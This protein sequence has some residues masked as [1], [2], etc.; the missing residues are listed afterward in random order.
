[1]SRTCRARRHHLIGAA[2]LLLVAGCTLPEDERRT[3]SS[4]RFG[5]TSQPTGVA[6]SNADL[7][8][9]FIDLT[10]GLE[11]GETLDGLLR[12]E[13][14]VQVMMRGRELAPYHRDLTAL[15]QR[16]R[17]E[18][19]IDITETGDP[20]KAEI[21]IEAVPAAQINRFFPDAACFIVPGVANWR[22]FLN[23]RNDE[24][25]RWSDQRTLTHSVIF[26]PPDSTPQDARDCLNEEITQALGPANDL[27]RLPDS[28]WND[29]NFQ[30][31]A[32]A[33]DM[34]MLRTLY[35]PEFASGMSRAQAE[36]RV[37]G[38]LDRVNPKGRGRPRQRRAPES[39]AWSGTI[40]RA[41]S[42]QTG[43][44]ERLQAAVSATQI[45]I[46]MEPP[47][48]RLGVSLLTLG[49]LNIRRDPAMAA[50]HFTDAYTVFAEELGVHDIRT[51]QAGVHVAALALGTAQYGVAIEL[52]DRHVPDAIAGQNAI[53][54]AGL[55]SI[56][57]ESL[58]EK[59]QDEA[60]REARLDSLRWARYGFGDDTGD[61]AR[62][63]VQLALMV[64]IG[65]K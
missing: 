14:P 62:E 22:E 21:V 38:V 58:A 6:R 60:A 7:S 27:Y 13:M 48:H 49:R 40:E 26:L 31:A 55:L 57:A 50:Q 16:L 37:G 29:D 63:Q 32:T 10:F 43:R 3:I 53:L 51:A 39:R 30:G 4:V 42:H 52:A 11:N 54:A 8:E 44:E 17:D 59:G 41:L 1:M 61:L 35:Q 18:A 19:G 65:P 28:I 36:A 5:D 45:A 25:I 56:K 12:Y 2:A 34:L 24:R 20:S 33:F 23:Q 46:E 9:D 64:P 47:D 15:L